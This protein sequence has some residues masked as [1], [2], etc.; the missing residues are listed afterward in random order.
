MD[1][2]T[3]CWFSLDLIEL[4]RQ[5]R[6]KEEGETEIGN[7]NIEIGRSGNRDH[8]IHYAT[9]TSRP[10]TAVT[11]R[12][13]TPECRHRRRCW[14]YLDKTRAGLKSRDRPREKDRPSSSV[15]TP[16]M[17]CLNAASADIKAQ[18]EKIRD[19]QPH[20]FISLFFLVRQNVLVTLTIV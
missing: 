7:I 10:R 4:W 3:L 15:Q 2:C 9:R 20:Y 6:K 14:P 8:A 12:D 1:Y 18:K 17:E 16:D 19:S 13:L 5:T 11:F